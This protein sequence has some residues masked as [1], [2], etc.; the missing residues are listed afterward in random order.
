MI[1]KMGHNSCQTG[2]RQRHIKKEKK[3]KLRHSRRET[4]GLQRPAAVRA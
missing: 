2:R 4:G 1:F 3:V